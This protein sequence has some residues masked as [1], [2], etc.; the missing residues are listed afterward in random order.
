[1][2]ERAGFKTSIDPLRATELGRW[3]CDKV[4]TAPRSGL[5]AA[6]LFPQPA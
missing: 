4:A 5:S 6:G 2:L 3:I 1:M